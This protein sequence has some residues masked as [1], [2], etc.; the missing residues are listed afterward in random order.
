MDEDERLTA[1]VGMVCMPPMAN[2]G[3]GEAPRALAWPLS[4]G[5]FVFTDSSSPEATE[6][7]LESL[8][9]DR[10]LVRSL[11]SAIGNFIG[12]FGVDS[13]SKNWTNA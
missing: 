13:V 10:L 4:T 1:N 9:W 12:T 7:L 11:I 8:D 6:L 2:S 5:L 3:L